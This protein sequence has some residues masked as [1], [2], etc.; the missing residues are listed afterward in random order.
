MKFLQNQM[1]MF[2]NQA[3]ALSVGLEIAYRNQELPNG[4]PLVEQI[5]SDLMR[6]AATLSELRTK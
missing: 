1:L 2:M 5:Y 6:A 4:G 3:R